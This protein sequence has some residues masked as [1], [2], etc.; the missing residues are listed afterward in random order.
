M[1][2]TTREGVPHPQRHE[3]HTTGR[4]GPLGP[5]P[6]Q[7]RSYGQRHDPA[8]ADLRNQ[9][10]DRL[11]RMN[12]MH[13]QHAWD[14][15]HKDPVA[16][17]GLA[18]LYAD[19]ASQ[20][21]PRYAL[22][23]ATRMFLDGPEVEHLPRLLYELIGI[24]RGYL[25]QGSFDPCTQMTD[26]QDEMSPWARYV[27]LGIS[28]LDTPQASWRQTRQQAFGPLDVP[29]RCYALLT[30]GT[31]LLMDR[32]GQ[33]RFGSF[34][35]RSTHSLDV[36]PGQPARIWRWAGDLTDLDSDPQT[37]PIWHWLHQLHQF[38]LSG[39][40]VRAAAGPTL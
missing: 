23:T 37:K 30:D 14:R 36:I 21:P 22:R 39:D 40:R 4:Y 28:S 8:A 2:Y 29:G 6:T 17:H 20:D 27:G 38:V 33:S 7:A 35:V 24:A 9:V 26:R 11:R 16:P 5:E 19:V 13:G 32:G 31:M 15:R 12:T 1:T 25:Q 34:T 18:F 10:V 3:A